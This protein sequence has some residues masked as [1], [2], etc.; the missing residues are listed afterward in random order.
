MDSLRRRIPFKVVEN[1]NED[2]DDS[3]IYDEQRVSLD[4]FL[5]TF[6]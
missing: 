1:D 3:I 6:D 4:N 2:N 5:V